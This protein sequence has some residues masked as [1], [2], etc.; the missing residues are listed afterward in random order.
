VPDHGDREETHLPYNR[1]PLSKGFL[2]AGELSRRPL[3]PRDRGD[4]ALDVDLRLGQR[5]SELDT[6]GRR[7]AVDGEWISY[8][9]LIIATGAAARKLPGTEGLAG[10]HTLRTVE[11]ALAI[12]DALDRGARTVV[13]GAG[14]VGS[15]VAAAARRRGLPVTLV[16]GDGRPAR[17][18]DRGG[19]GRRGLAAARGDGA[20]L[21]C[22]VTVTACPAPGTSS[23][24]T[25]P[26]E[27]CSTPTSL[28]SG[29]GPCRRPAG[30]N[31]PHWT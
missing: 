14:F 3:A 20:E 12:R 25:C 16:E 1:P 29:S 13:V 17:A 6:A 18:G 15:E 30:S 31:R 23:G 4:R 27:P 28:S 22:G 19:P 21:R 26:T 9:A 8:A 7:V 10:V 5:A 11:D 2:G 24:C